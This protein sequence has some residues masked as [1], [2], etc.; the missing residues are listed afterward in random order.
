MYGHDGQNYPYPKKGQKKEP[1]PLFH[2]TK[3]ISL[4]SIAKAQN[5]TI[6]QVREVIRKM[7]GKKKREVLMIRQPH[8]AQPMTMNEVKKTPQ[9][10][11]K[12]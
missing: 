3:R 9:W 1:E 8:I 2:P 5:I 4:A 6:E 10:E 12:F 7:K 11:H